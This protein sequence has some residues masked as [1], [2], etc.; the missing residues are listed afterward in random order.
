[1]KKA[2]VII[3]LASLVLSMTGC[4]AFRN[5]IGKSID[6]LGAKDWTVTLFSGGKAVRTYEVKNSFVNSEEGT[7]GYFFYIDGKL[8]RIT[9][10]VEISCNQ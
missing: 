6:G 8:I 5:K 3:T 10:C 1:M 9:G 4:G 7:D 2:I